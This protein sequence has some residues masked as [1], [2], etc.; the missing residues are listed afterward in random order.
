MTDFIKHKLA[1]RSLIRVV[2]VFGMITLL[3]TESAEAQGRKNAY[4]ITVSRNE[5]GICVYT[6]ENQ[7]DQDL[8]KISP[9]GF[10]TFFAVDTDVSIE[11]ERHRDAPHTGVRGLA[12]RQPS[13]FFLDLG[14]SRTVR[15]RPSF[16]RTIESRNTKHK[17]WITCL[18]DGKEI[19]SKS[20]KNIEMK[21]SP[22]KVKSDD[23]SFAALDVRGPQLPAVRL[24][25]MT[26]LPDPLRRRV[27]GG[28]T[29][30]VDDP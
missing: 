2:L 30:E 9:R 19:L 29:M 5:S 10:V 21:E 26:K 4:T 22:G 13:A 12:V 8:F 27:P 28:P 18:V 16:P 15:V 11:I 24:P 7:V 6:I 17:V 3:L 14:K 1:L 25:D 20:E 23:A